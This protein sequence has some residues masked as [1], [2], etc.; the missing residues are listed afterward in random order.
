M[1][2][3]VSLPVPKATRWMPVSW[4]SWVERILT[5][6]NHLNQTLSDPRAENVNP[7]P[8]YSNSRIHSFNKPFN[9][10]KEYFPVAL[11]LFSKPTLPVSLD[12][13]K[14]YPTLEAA[15]QA[16][17]PE[18][19]AFLKAHKHPKPNQT[20]I[21][22]YQKLHSPQ[23]KAS[24]VIIRTKAR[25]MLALLSQLERSSSKSKSMTKR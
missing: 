17:V 19:A 23:L 13:L 2:G 9:C 15:R 16:S 4:Q 21:A 18:L 25:L 10:L 20:A 12:F 11:E 14:L 24:P 7:R 22:V 6:Y 3:D 5:N 8:G 1:T